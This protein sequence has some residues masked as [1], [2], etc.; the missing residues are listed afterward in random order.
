[1]NENKK[2]LLSSGVIIIFI[3][4]IL[5]GGTLAFLGN[6]TVLNPFA[7]TELPLPPPLEAGANLHDDFA[8]MDGVDALGYTTK[9]IYVENT[10]ERNVFVRIQLFEELDG[11]GINL[12]MPKLSTAGV[13]QGAGNTAGFEWTLGSTT[14]K[15]YKSITETTEWNDLVAPGQNT[16][17]VADALGFAV[18]TIADT[19]PSAI[20]VAGQTQDHSG[21]ISMTQYTALNAA[22]KVAFVGWVYD[23]DGFAY[24]SQML[25]P[26]QATGRL[27][28]SVRVPGL[29]L[30]KFDYDIT[31]EMEYV[32]IY[33]MDAWVS[34]GDDGERVINTNA[35][36]QWD[37]VLTNADGAEIKVGSK[38]GETT[39]E[40]S[41][42]AKQLLMGL[43]GEANVLLHAQTGDGTWIEI[44]KQGEFSLIVKAET[45]GQTRY[46]ESPIIP[47]ADQ[48]IDTPGSLRYV[49]NNWYD[50]TLA[51]DAPLR[52]YVIAHDALIR[53]GVGRENN[54]VT[55]FSRPMGLTPSA[56][57]VAFPLSYQEA[58]SYLSRQWRNSANAVVPSDADAIANFDKLTDRSVHGSWLRTLSNISNNWGTTI[59]TDGLLGDVTFNSNQYARPAL[60]VR[61]AIFEH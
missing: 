21:V 49:I 13:I 47:Y 29:E 8:G 26:G 6:A 57:D 55:G 37:E 15:D 28:T 53:P 51:A 5:T 4:A 35:D 45:V 20:P 40:A 22:Q 24:W 44:A 52:D 19:S 41:T 10:G 36:G 39:I 46:S 27:M 17:L 43:I 25:S 14:P 42:R 11:D 9:D 58:V 56:T 60:W 54:N 59:L 2:K 34:V 50:N 32:D 38:A 48:D 33:D 3:L 12:F 61:S 16:Q 23:V 30:L 18:G 1:M 7:D 31:I